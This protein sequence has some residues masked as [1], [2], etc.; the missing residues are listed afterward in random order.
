MKDPHKTPWI[1]EQKKSPWIKERE[2]ADGTGPFFYRCQCAQKAKG[3]NPRLL[4]TLCYSP[5]R[6]EVWFWNAHLHE[7]ECTKM[8]ARSWADAETVRRL[9]TIS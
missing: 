6:K 7:G 1:K 8:Q 2:N 3:G 4:Y 9:L 5:R